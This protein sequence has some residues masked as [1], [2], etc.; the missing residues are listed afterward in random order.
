M[1]SLP[2]SILATVQRFAESMNLVAAPARDGSY[3]FEFETTGT[4]SFTPSAGGTGPAVMS[5]SRELR[6]PRY[7]ALPALLRQAGYDAALD[8][9]I[10]VGLSRKGRAVVW[11]PLGAERFELSDLMAAW[12]RLRAVAAAA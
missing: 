7:A 10:H 8:R 3:I 4:L 2:N 5:L 1:A 11:T 6:S 12:N 9:T